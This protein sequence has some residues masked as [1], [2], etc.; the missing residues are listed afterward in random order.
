MSQ[1]EERDAWFD[2][3]AG[4]LLDDISPYLQFLDRRWRAHKRIHEEL[5]AAYQKGWQDRGRIRPSLSLIG[6][7]AGKD[8]TE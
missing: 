4:K 7:G 2:V 3:L 6:D 1:D 8:S 5:E